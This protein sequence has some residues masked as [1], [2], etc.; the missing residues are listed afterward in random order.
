M[1]VLALTG[2]VMTTPTAVQAEARKF[3]ICHVP[4]GNPENAHTITIGFPAL[5]PRTSR[6]MT[7]TSANVV[8]AASRRSP[9]I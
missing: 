4:P 2:M 6:T 8:V 5:V 9:E 1:L 7:T 3:T